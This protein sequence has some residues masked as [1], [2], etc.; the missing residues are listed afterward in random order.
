MRDPYGPHPK[1]AAAHVHGD[2]LFILD[3]DFKF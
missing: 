3:L 1:F 2:F